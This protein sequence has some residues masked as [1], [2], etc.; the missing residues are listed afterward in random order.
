VYVTIN[1][2]TWRSNTTSLLAEKSYGV[3]KTIAF[4]ANKLVV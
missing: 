2:G 3:N 1:E 4:S